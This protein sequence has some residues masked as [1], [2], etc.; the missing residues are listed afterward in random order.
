MPILLA[1]TEEPTLV[2]LSPLHRGFLL[3]VEARI[4]RS[5]LV[6]LGLRLNLVE[7]GGFESPLP[8]DL[9]WGSGDPPHMVLLVPLDE[10]D[11]FEHVC[12]VVYPTLLHFQHYHGDIEIQAFVWGLHEQAYKLLR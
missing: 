4:L 1:L 8:V 11:S 5:L 2:W 9:V 7:G 3:G 10:V 12:D 6:Q